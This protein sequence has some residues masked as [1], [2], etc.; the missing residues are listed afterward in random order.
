MQGIPEAVRPRFDPVQLGGREGL[1]PAGPVAATL[2]AR[3]KSTTP[4]I[5]V[6]PLPAPATLAELAKLVSPPVMV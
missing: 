4:A 2:S 1:V 5:E 6:R 3:V